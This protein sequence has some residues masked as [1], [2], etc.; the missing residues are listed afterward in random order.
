MSDHSRAKLLA[1]GTAWF[2]NVSSSVAIIFVN[3]ILMSR[4]GYGFR[5]G[6]A[7]AVALRRMRTGS[8][9]TGCFLLQKD[10]GCCT[11]YHPGSWHANPDSCELALE[12]HTLLLDG[13]KLEKTVLRGCSRC[14]TCTRQTRSWWPCAA[15]MVACGCD[16]SGS[17]CSEFGICSQRW[18]QRPR[19]PLREL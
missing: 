11:E 1:D 18:S 3:K 4:T 6:E 17:M 2:G 15:V 19:A 13:Y 14:L 7:R 10:P 12:L 8:C 9:H 5:Y 16:E